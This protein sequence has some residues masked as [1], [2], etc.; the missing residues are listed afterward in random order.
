MKPEYQREKL[1]QALGLIYRSERMYVKE[2]FKRAQWWA[3]KNTIEKAFKDAGI[4]LK[5]YT[6]KAY[7]DSRDGIAS[8]L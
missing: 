2:R 8:D 4:N 6:P 7:R 3:W 5:K 1:A